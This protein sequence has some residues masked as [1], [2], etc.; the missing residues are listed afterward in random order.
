MLGLISF[1]VLI[2][3]LALTV[4]ICLLDPFT[5]ILLVIIIAVI[6]CKKGKKKGDKNE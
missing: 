6:A 3:V 5:F 1:I 2:I 4:W